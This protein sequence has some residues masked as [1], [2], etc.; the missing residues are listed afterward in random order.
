VTAGW[1]DLGNRLDPSGTPTVP[2]AGY[3]EVE[4]ATMRCD[5]L[6]TSGALQ[7]QRADT[8]SSGMNSLMRLLTTTQ[9]S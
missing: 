4:F 1:V 9:C 7:L 6:L 5:Y 3:R 2:T 8:K